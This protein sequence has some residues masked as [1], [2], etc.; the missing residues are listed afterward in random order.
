MNIIT[1]YKHFVA[2]AK[3]GVIVIYLENKNEKANSI[4]EH[5]GTSLQEQQQF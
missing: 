5:V 1:V 2:Q 3:R 4:F